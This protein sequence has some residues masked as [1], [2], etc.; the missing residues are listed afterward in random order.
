MTP[1]LED[2]KTLSKDVFDQNLISY[3]SI[4]F[5]MRDLGKL[6]PGMRAKAVTYFTNEHDLKSDEE[7]SNL[8]VVANPNFLD[9]NR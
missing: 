7:R 5:E 3:S 8:Y 2:L 4:A 9:L 6:P 1:V